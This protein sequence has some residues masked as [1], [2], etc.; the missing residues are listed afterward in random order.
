MH[1]RPLSA[2]MWPPICKP[3]LCERVRGKR[4]LVSPRR[5]AIALA[6]GSL[7]GPK[8]GN[9][10][11]YATEQSRFYLAG[12]KMFRPLSRAREGTATLPLLKQFR[13]KKRKKISRF[14]NS[15]KSTAVTRVP[16]ISS[17]SE[18]RRLLRRE[19]SSANTRYYFVA[20]K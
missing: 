6:T 11:P 17:S 20:Q 4:A 9:C 13:K 1:A 16:I 19:L 2:I 10:P 18:Q 7:S 12:R 5:A 8:R 15:D 3:T 14:S